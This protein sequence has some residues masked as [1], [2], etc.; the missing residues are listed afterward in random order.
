MIDRYKT[1]RYIQIHGQLFYNNPRTRPLR[2]TTIFRPTLASES[3]WESSRGAKLV[4]WRLGA[5]P[6]TTAPGSLSNSTV[7]LC[8]EKSQPLMTPPLPFK[9]AR[10]LSSCRI[11]WACDRPTDRPTAPPAGRPAATCQDLQ[12]CR[13][14]WELEQRKPKSQENTEHTGGC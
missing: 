5:S 10:D 13:S 3:V 1:E 9:S 2:S 8:K 6:T 4:Y 7:Y 12:P 14:R 11:T